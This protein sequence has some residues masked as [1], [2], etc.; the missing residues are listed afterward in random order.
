MV[1]DVVEHCCI[2]NFLSGHSSTGWERTVW[3]CLLLLQFYQF[4]LCVYLEFLGVYTSGFLDLGEWTLPSRCKMPF[5]L[6][7]SAGVISTV[8]SVPSIL[9][10]NLSTE[11]LKLVIVFL[12]LKFT[13]GSSLYLLFLR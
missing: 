1:D 2:P 11:M 9:L 8:C 4:L 5:S 6:C 3:V 12:V 10:L 7:C 13:F